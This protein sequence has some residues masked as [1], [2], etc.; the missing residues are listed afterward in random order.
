MLL[1][2]FEFFLHEFEV[3]ARVSVVGFELQRGF[4]GLDCLLPDG[5]GLFRIS[6]L[7]LLPLAILGI[8]EVVIGV[9]LQVDLIRF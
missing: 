3:V 4:V 9:L 5:D 7:E 6:L 2:L 8:A 1:K